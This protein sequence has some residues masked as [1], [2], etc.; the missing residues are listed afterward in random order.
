MT[1]DVETRLLEEIR[2]RASTE[3]DES[4]PDQSRNHRADESHDDQAPE[5]RAWSMAEEIEF[6]DSL[7]MVGDERFGFGEKEEKNE[8]EDE[9][10]GR[11]EN[12]KAQVE[13]DLEAGGLFGS[14]AAE[15]TIVF[16]KAVEGGRIGILESDCDSVVAG[17]VGAPVSLIGPGKKRDGN[18]DRLD[19]VAEASNGGGES[20]RIASL[21]RVDDQGEANTFGGLLGNRRETLARGK[22]KIVEIE[23]LSGNEDGNHRIARIP[24]PALGFGVEEFCGNRLE[25]DFADD[26]GDCSTPN[27]DGGGEVVAENGFCD[28]H[29]FDFANAL[30]QRGSN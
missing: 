8:D 14:P 29:S 28:T 15:E 5:K 13:E 12:S 27:L 4:E 18:E 23:K 19:L 21:R 7:A 17:G 24:L 30:K 25:K 9:S 6:M 26:G 16:Q 2:D 1:L 3:P 10:T 20:K 22:S 11:A